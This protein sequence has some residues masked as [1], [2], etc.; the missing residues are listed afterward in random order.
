MKQHF[1][2]F[3]AYNQWANGRIYE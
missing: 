2:M 1:M 3:A